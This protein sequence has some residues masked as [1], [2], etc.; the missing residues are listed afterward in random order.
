MTVPVARHRLRTRPPRGPV[1]LPELLQSP[2]EIQPYLQDA[3]HYPG[4][5]SP[6]AALPR[7]EGEMAALL[8]QAPHLL[9]V[10]AQ[11][12]L[13][14]GATPRGEWIAST[15]RMTDLQFPRSD[16]VRAQA[17]V[18]LLTLNRELA[19]R[20]S[21]YPAATTFSGALMGGTVGTNAAG[22]RTFK[23]GATRE[24]VRAL[25][26]LLANGEVL[27][28]ER[29][30]ARAHPDGY[31]EIE[32]LERE[33][34]RVPLPTYRMPDVRKRSAGYHFEA[35]MDLLD[36][37]IGSEG[38]LGIVT[39]VEF[40]VLPV[41]F[42]LLIGLL[43]CP[44]E[45]IALRLAAELC[46]ASRSTWTSGKE[47]GLDI[48]SLEMIDRPGLDLVRE[49]RAGNLGG[50]RLEKHWECVLIFEVELRGETEGD[51][52]PLGQLC[53][54]LEN[55]G[56]L[57]ELQVALPGENQRAEGIRALREAVPLALHNW[58]G[59]ARRRT[60]QPLRKVAADMIVPFDAV[61]QALRLYRE[62][63]RRRD[64]DFAIW[65]HLSDGNLHANVLPRSLEEVRKGEEAILEFGVQVSRMGGCPLSEHGVGRNQVKQA[66][67][68]QLY[69]ERGI[70][71]MRRVKRALDPDLIL[72]P[73]VLFPV[74]AAQS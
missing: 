50:I 35:E 71:E 38:T 34:I 48:P 43:G 61:G 13:T 32:T 73:G 6:C 24:W 9:V 42:Q 28:L 40:A 22:P 44:R 5:H 11:S 36:L 37:F 2:A 54:I 45:R 26:L 14:G 74:T 62:G 20:G 70:E 29:G 46:E 72:A 57:E 21:F 16:R 55:H 18:P 30:E 66:L 41:D 33:V 51:R 3:A 49:D 8:Q 60:G 17:G 52:S 56:L 1:R 67:L 63:F 58:I 25:R 39:E 15:Q 7:Q 23:Y 10:G 69:G 31:F 27:E 65:G 4:G 64:L 12:S 53:R 47:S 68:R 19:E 59:E